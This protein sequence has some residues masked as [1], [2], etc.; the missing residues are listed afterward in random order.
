MIVLTIILRNA[1]ETTQTS[2]LKNL[3][4]ILIVLTAEKKL[5]RLKMSDKNWIKFEDEMP[6][7]GKKI[8]VKTLGNLLIKA[9]F[10]QSLSSPDM[11]VL[12]P[13]EGKILGFN[14]NLDSNPSHWRPIP[15]KK[16]DFQKLTPLDLLEVEYKYEE[17]EKYH[18]VC[19]YFT[20]INYSQNYMRLDRAGSDSYCSRYVR[21]YLDS[22]KKITRINIE[23]QTFEE[24]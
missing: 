2:M 7:L 12:T 9:K 21:L 11:F 6:P 20:K 19:G 15:D 10:L 13:Q 4:G 18:K 22:I 24:I 14:F 3:M 5:R 8:Q 16:P 17:Y 23:N 1:S